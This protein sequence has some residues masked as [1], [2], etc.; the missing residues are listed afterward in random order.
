MFVWCPQGRCSLAAESYTLQ[1]VVVRLVGMRNAR[2]K[3]V[4]RYFQLRF[5][6]WTPFRNMTTC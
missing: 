5:S 6:L 1:Y 4:N 3:T 2:A